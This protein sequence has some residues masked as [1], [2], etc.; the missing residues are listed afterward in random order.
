LLSDDVERRGQRTAGETTSVAEGFDAIGDLR[1]RRTVKI[2]GRVR[3][4]AVS[5]TGGDSNFECVVTDDTGSVTLVFQGREAV[6]GIERGTR[7]SATGMV[8]ARQR[9]AVIYNPLYDILEASAG[10]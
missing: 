8:V 10:H 2:S 5:G 9:D 6:P 4:V 3:S 7:L 1:A